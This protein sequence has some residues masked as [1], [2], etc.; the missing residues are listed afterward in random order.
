MTIAMNERTRTDHALLRAKLKK[1]VVKNRRL[2]MIEERTLEMLADTEV[3]VADDLLREKEAEELRQ[4]IT[5]TELWVL[6]IIG[7]SGSTKTTSMETVAEKLKKV[8][9]GKTPVLMVKCRSSTR[10]AKQLQVQ[11]LEAFRDPQAEYIRRQISSYSHDAAMHAI[12]KV[13]RGA[14]THIVVLDE[15]HSMLGRDKHANAKTMAVAIKSLVND[16]VFSV[17]VMGTADA[18]LL[19]EVDE[20]CNSRK[21]DKISLEPANLS[22]AQDYEYFF[23]F[24]GR[25]DREMVLQGIIDQPI[26]LVDDIDS[27]AILYDLSGG[28]VGVVSRILMLALR[29][30]QRDGRRTIGWNDIKQGFWTWKAEQKDEDGNP[31]VDIYDPF[32]SNTKRTT[33]DAI[34]E[35]SKKLKV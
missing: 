17:V 30:S 35:M 10:T 12:R 20:E 13:A 4:R 1:M 3:L 7:K 34:R 33:V 27:R 29:I 5:Y 21:F 19:F 18:D 32:K 6:P 24:V 14:G 23:K 8:R 16:G 25:V 11:I 26:G 28:V 2:D 22:N 9:K 15:A 31:I